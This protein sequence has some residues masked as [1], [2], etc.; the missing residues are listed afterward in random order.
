MYIRIIKKIKNIKTYYLLKKKNK[1][2]FNI[3]NKNDKINLIEYN[4]FNGSH[5]CQALLSNFLKQKNS[6]KIVAYYNYTLMVSLLKIN[7]LQKFKWHISSFLN[8]GFKGIYKSFGTDKFIRP[9]TK[10]NFSYKAELLAKKFFKKKINNSK[11]INYKIGDIWIG[12]LLYDTY[13]KSKLIPTINIKDKKFFIYFKEFLELFFYWKE[14]YEKNDIVSTTG[15]H[16]CYSYG[17]PLRISIYKKIP[18]YVINTRGVMRIDKKVQAMF[19]DFKFH[20]K[21]FAAFS[22]KNKK[23]YLKIAKKI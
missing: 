8:L 23:K 3:K 10:K 20:K 18:T 1:F 17:I 7:Y 16:S 9:E 14:F 4:N 2:F 22:N 11:I 12:D 19:G 15:I 13:L 6:G 5:L 21:K